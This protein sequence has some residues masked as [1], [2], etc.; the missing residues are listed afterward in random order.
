LMLRQN[1]FSL[2]LNQSTETTEV[3][4]ILNINRGRDLI[5]EKV[6]EEFDED[7]FRESLLI[8]RLQRHMQALGAYGF[9]S[10]VKGKTYF[11]RHIPEGLRLLKEDITVM[12]DKYPALHQL[13]MSCR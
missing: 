5:K 3:R 2:P 6:Q 8:C 7:T 9:L 13:I 1:R 12:K 10:S 4:G 11:L